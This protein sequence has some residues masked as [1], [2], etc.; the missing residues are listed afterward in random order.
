MCS[1]KRSVTVYPKGNAAD[2]V[3]NGCQSSMTRVA[4]DAGTLYENSTMAFWDKGAT[5]SLVVRTG[6]VVSCREIPLMSRIEDARIRGVS[7][8][9]HSVDSSWSIEI[10]P[11]PSLRFNRDGS[12]P[13]TFGAPARVINPNTGATLYTASKGNR[14]ILVEVEPE[15]CR[16]QAGNTLPGAVSVSLDGMVH[17]GCGIPLSR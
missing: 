3:V 5:A 8:R 11:G 10:G 15:R 6:G 2:I 12:P 17:E 16:D 4:A 9:G 14:T 1:D 7:W 13:D